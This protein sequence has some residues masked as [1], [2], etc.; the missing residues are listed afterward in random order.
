MMFWTSTESGQTFLQRGKGIP[1]INGRGK[2]DQYVVI[3]IQVPTKLTAEQRELL[4][5]F[6]A[7]TGERIHE[8]GE[9]KGI[10][11]RLFGQ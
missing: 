9:G 8:G 7:T 4:R 11:G 6:A 3:R 10:L 2:G 1:D 5:Q